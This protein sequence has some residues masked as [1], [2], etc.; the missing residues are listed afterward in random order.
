MPPYRDLLSFRSEAPTAPE[1][2]V[3]F[4]RDDESSRIC[5]T[6]QRLKRLGA[7]MISMQQLVEQ[8][9]HWENEFPVVR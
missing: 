3:A 9:H 2:F 6:C 5:G 7:H 8:S 1:G 4:L